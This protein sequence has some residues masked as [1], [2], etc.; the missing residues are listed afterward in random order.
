MLKVKTTKRNFWEF[1][2][3]IEID[4]KPPTTSID[5]V[6]LE[7]CLIGQIGSLFR[8]ITSDSYFIS[9]EILY[10]IHDIEENPITFTKES[11]ILDPNPKSITGHLVFPFKFT[12]E[13]KK[14][15]SYEGTNLRY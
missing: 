14:Y 3:V 6:F 7:V 11:H 4:L 10:S 12:S 2:G 13:D 5:Y 9:L 1:L 8:I 15:E